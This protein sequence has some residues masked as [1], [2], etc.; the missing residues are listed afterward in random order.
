MKELLGRE[1]EM[2]SVEDR[3]I[4]HF[5]EVFEMSAA[6]RLSAAGTGEPAAKRNL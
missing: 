2:S 5:A 4:E 3:I 1:V 6:D